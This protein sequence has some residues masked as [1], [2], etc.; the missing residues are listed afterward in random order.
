MTR[1]Q[2]PHSTSPVNSALPPRAD[3]RDIR[4]FMGA[5]SAIIADQLLKARSLN[6]TRAELCQVIIDDGDRR[7]SDRTGR[8]GQLILPSLALGV[9]DDLAHVRL[10]NVDNGT[11]VKMLRRDLRAHLRLSRG[12]APGPSIILS[13][14]PGAS[15][16]VP[17][18]AQARPRA[19][20]APFLTTFVEPTDRSHIH[21]GSMH[22]RQHLT[23]TSRISV[24]RVF[25]RRIT[26]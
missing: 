26:G 25:W 2:R 12:S 1:P 3:F 21:A 15:R 9:I 14:R 8:F 10:E 5:F 17:R 7:E 22:D 13:W 23:S 11:S 20:P 19:Q 4:F 6:Q 24:P 16:A 18:A